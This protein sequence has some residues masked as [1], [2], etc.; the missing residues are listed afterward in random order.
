MIK[1][2]ADTTTEKIA[3][4]RSLTKKERNRFGAL[5]IDKAKQRLA[6]LH[7]ADEKALLMAPFLSYHSLQGTNR[8]SI[9]ADSRRSPWR[10]TFAWTNDELTD[11]ELVQIEDTH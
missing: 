2:F 11:V 6:L 3:L 5:N 10:I 8:Y 1:K 9:D 7:D 4:G